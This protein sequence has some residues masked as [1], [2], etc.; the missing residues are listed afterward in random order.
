MNNSR[1]S[2]VLSRS[3]I[4]GILGLAMSSVAYSGSDQRHHMER[5][6]GQDH[7]MHMNMLKE[8]STTRKYTK[9]LQAITFQ[10]MA[11]EEAD[12]SRTSAHKILSNDHPIL[13]TFIFTSCGTI[14]PI[15]SAT[16]SRVKDEIF[17]ITGDAR[18]ISITIDPD[19]DTPERLLEYSSKYGMDERWRF[20]RGD[21]RDTIRLEKEFGI[22][23]GNKMNHLPAFFVK[24]PNREHWLKI[25]GFIGKENLIAEY[26]AYVSE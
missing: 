26:K 24:A 4:I 21:I 16:V 2:I 1:F 7:M 5:I 22:Y 14:C 12:G 11:L 3:C 17:G 10:D 20:V 6:N 18:I 9:S 13:V 15:L 23:R 25:D 8:N 19:Y